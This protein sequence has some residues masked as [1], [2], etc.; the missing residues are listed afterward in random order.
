MRQVSFATCIMLVII[1]VG[2]C[3]AVGVIASSDPYQKLAVAD[4]LA[5]HN[6]PAVAE[7]LIVESIAICKE[8]DDRHCFAAAYRGYGLFF[9]SESIEGRQWKPHYAQNGFIDSTV[10][11]DDRYSRAIDFL[12]KSRNIYIENGEYDAVTNLSLSIGFAYVMQGDYSPACQAYDESLQAYA[13]NVRNNPNVKIH[14]PEKYANF[15]NY[16]EIQKNRILCKG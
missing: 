7:R 14:L 1:S 13:E 4:S 15:P 11:L 6:R 16:I 9:M 10:S 12:K 5:E 3:S 8:T 2:G